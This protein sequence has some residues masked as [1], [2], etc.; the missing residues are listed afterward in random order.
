MLR[1]NETDR[2]P[3]ADATATH[4]DHATQ[5]DHATPR[6]VENGRTAAPPFAA[7]DP[8]DLNPPAPP[9]IRPVKS[10]DEGFGSFS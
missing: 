5:Q 4:P 7:P 3:E 9:T 2:T 1:S 10:S 8:N 6:D